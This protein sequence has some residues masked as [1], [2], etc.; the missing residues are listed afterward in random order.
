MVYNAILNT[1]PVGK[2]PSELLGTSVKSKH[3]GVNLVKRKKASSTKALFPY[4][5]TFQ[6]GNSFTFSECLSQQE[7]GQTLNST[8]LMRGETLSCVETESAV[9]IQSRPKSDGGDEN[10]R[11]KGIEMGG[12]RG[13]DESPL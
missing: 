8:W 13:V 9:D 5:N 4:Y 3:T 1:Q 6:H 7:D 10:F 11:D 2:Y 12:K